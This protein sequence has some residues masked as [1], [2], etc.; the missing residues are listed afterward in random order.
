LAATPNGKE[1]AVDNGDGTASIYLNNAG[2]AVLRRTIIIDPSAPSSASLLGFI[3]SGANARAET[4]QTALRREVWADQYKLTG[5]ADDREC[6]IRAVNA[7]MG[8]AGGGVV[9]LSRR[10]YVLGSGIV[11]T[12]LN[13]VRIVGAG[14][15][16]NGTL[17]REAF[18]N[19]DAITFSN[20]QGCEIS[21]VAFWPTV[22]KTGG[23]SVVLTGGCYDCRVD[24]RTDF[25]YNGLLI[26]G[27][28]ETRYKLQTR[29]MLGVLGAL[30]TGTNTSRS[31][32]CIVEDHLGDNPYPNG[33]IGPWNY[34]T[35]TPNMSLSVD[36]HFIADGKIWQCIQAGQAG[37]SPPSGLPP[38]TSPESAFF[39][40][41][42]NG[43][44]VLRFVS[45]ASFTHLV[46]DNYAYSL[47]ILAAALINGARGFV[48]QDTANTGTSYPIWAFVLDL[49]C[50]HN[51]TVGVDLNRGDGFYAPGAVWIGSC[52]TGCGVV[53]GPNFKGCVSFGSGTRIMGNAEHGIL[54]HAGPIDVRLTGVEVV[55][56][57][58]KQNATY[59]GLTLGGG[60]AETHVVGG[61]F[62]D[63]PSVLGNNQGYGIFV[64]NGCDKT[65]IV[66]ADVRG[67]VTGGIILGSPQTDLMIRDCPGYNAAGPVS[68]TVGASPF[69]YTNTTGADVLVRVS[70]GTVSNIS[71]DG[72][73]IATATNGQFLV[74][75]GA[76]LVVTY[77]A[78]PT[79]TRRVL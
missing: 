15:N 43:S 68:I 70:G 23:F 79:M 7:V 13:N 44:A 27:A 71:M 74:P 14:A 47:V 39:T 76:T 78:A 45:N 51:Y 58:V 4:I 3:Q 8:A 9:R 62:G 50:D 38:G 33:D 17:I 37:S 49:E 56:N 31:Y 66:G 35:F 28:T 11:F 40:N 52:T 61:R 46:Q 5:D 59:H 75:A 19:G 30:F 73:T 65:T 1:F 53:I 16:A 41:V 72:A 12:N 20:C 2:V 57:S 67:N 36:D 24:I 34:K 48:M 25:G 29:H 18:T 10:H 69:S 77:S 63:S 64:N 54:R 6:I 22:R 42:T 21:E 26:N 60:S 55:D 32:R